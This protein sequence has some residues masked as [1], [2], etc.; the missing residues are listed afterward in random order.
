MAARSRSRR[1]K[2]KSVIQSSDY[3]YDFSCYPCSNEGKNT[4]GLFKC[5]DCVQYFCDKCLDFHK[6]SV[7]DHTIIRASDT[8]TKQD[9]SCILGASYDGDR[10]YL[11]NR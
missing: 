8:Y 3:I 4:E 5:V 10:N 1:R 9:E 2:K 11:Q 7:E 6:Q